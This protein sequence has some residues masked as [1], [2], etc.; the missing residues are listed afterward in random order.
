MQ[1]S[2][3]TDVVDYQ[4]GLRA[5]TTPKGI[6]CVEVDYWANTDRPENGEWANEQRRLYHTDRDWRREMERDWTSPAGDPFFS[7]FVEIGEAHYVHMASRIITGG[8]GKPPVPVYRAYDLGELR[9]ACIWFQ[10]SPI[11]DR[12]WFYREFMPHDLGT[13]HFRDAV[14][15]LSNQLPYEVLDPAARRWVDHYASKPSGAHCPPPW[16]PP[17]THF[18]DVSGK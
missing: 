10:Y 14:R 2:R 12:L 3:A 16:F 17:G 13:H 15:Y 5:Y 7:E 9:P 8:P 4:P 11:S 6:R 1:L 18:V